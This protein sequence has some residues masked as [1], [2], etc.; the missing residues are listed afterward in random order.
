MVSALI[1]RLSSPGFSPG[2]GHCVVLLGKTLNSH[3]TSLHPGVLMG[4]SK[5][6][7]GG[8][9]AMDWHPI[10]AMQQKSEV[11]AGLMDHLA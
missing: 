1:S 2:Q 3:S 5:F 9:P 10:Q 4:T 7:A 6:N 11:T 8:N